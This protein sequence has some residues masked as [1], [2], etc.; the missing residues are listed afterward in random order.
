MAE[1]TKIEVQKKD[2]TRSNI[3][4]DGEFFCGLQ[5]EVV[6]GK[7]LKV[8]LEI[9]EDKLKEIVLESEKQVAFNKALSLLNT[10]FKTKHEIK[11]YLK[12]KGF[13]EFVIDETIEKLIEYKYINDE[14]YA[15]AYINS[16]KVKK[17]KKVIELELLKKGV[18]Q[19]IINET[20]ANLETES[21]LILT[22]YTKYMK[23]K[24]ATFEN[25]QKAIKYLMG[26]GFSYDDIKK[27]VNYSDYE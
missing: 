4:L 2:K 17:S 15:E 21:E 18:S 6:I 11:T 27:A 8:G 10:R 9:D 26:K 3:F 12:E 7:G 1:I 14:H 22:L 20:L 24:E 13:D 19:K 25:K 5:N 16:N 23:N